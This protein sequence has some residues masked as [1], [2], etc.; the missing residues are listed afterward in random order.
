MK[1]LQPPSFLSMTFSENHEGNTA[2]ATIDPFMTEGESLEEGEAARVVSFIEDFLTLYV[3]NDP[4][5]KL[6]SDVAGVGADQ[7]RNIQVLNL[8]EKEGQLIAET[9]FQLSFIEGNF[10][11]STARL[12]ISGEAGSYF[13]DSVTPF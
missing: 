3:Q 4:N 5:L 2:K 8:V 7:V 10:F 1:V 11:T 6:V 12:T 9:S 13:V